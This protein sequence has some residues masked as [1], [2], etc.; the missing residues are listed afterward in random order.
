MASRVQPFCCAILIEKL[1]GKNEEYHSFFVHYCFWMGWLVDWCKY[2]FDDRLL[3]ECCWKP[4]GCLYRRED[5]PELLE[6]V[7]DELG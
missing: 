5:K 4:I 6:L 7:M 1:V 2:R 3:D